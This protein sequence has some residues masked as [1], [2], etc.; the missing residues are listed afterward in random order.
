MVSNEYANFGFAIDSK[1]RIA[2]KK[3]VARKKT[4]A[5]TTKVKV[6]NQLKNT[7]G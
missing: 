1:M 7:K 5:T 3:L 6:N 4:Q 2:L